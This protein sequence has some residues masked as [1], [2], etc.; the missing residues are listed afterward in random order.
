MIVDTLEN[1]GR[2]ACLGKHFPAAV[3]FVQHAD[4]TALPLGVTRVEGEN[5][6]VNLQSFTAAPHE[7]A[8]EAHARYADIQ[9]ILRGREKFGYAPRALLHPLKEGTDF[10]TCTAEKAFYFD[11]QEG[12]YAIFLPAEAHDPCHSVDETPEEVL[13]LVVKVL[14]EA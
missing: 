3:R 2:Y 12:E 7:P 11:L 5:V 8:W 14:V 9:L 13:K 4:L 1:L 6:F 10:R